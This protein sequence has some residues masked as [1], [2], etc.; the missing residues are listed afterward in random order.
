MAKVTVTGNA[1]VITSSIKFED[2]KIIKKYRPDALVLYKGEGKEK[3][4]IFK[5]GI[6]AGGNGDLNKYGATFCGAT[7][8]DA[9]LGVITLVHE[10]DG[11]DIKEEVSDFLGTSILNLNKLEAALPAAVE[12]IVAEKA[13]IMENVTLV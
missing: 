13:A 1:V 2:M 8:D 3:E 10:F 5:I 7:H 4:A 12:E 6:G 9:K 11:E